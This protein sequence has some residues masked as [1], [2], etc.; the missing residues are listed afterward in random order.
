LL[1]AEMIARHADAA[2]QRLPIAPDDLDTDLKADAEWEAI[3]FSSLPVLVLREFVTDLERNDMR[4]TQERCA[5]WYASKCA[6]DILLAPS[7][8]P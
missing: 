8:V 6:L 4:S 5:A 3:D 7:S 2:L 1:N